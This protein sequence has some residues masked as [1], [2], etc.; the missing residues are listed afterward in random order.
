MQDGKSQPRPHCARVHDYRAGRQASG[1]AF[2]SVQVT[3]QQNTTETPIRLSLSHHPVPF[4]VSF[5]WIH[6][7]RYSTAGSKDVTQA[8]CL[9]AGLT[10]RCKA[11]TGRS[12][13]LPVQ[14]KEL[15]APFTA[16]ACCGRDGLA[17]SGDSLA[18]RSASA[19]ACGFCSSDSSSCTSPSGQSAPGIGSWNATSS[20][21]GTSVVCVSSICSP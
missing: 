4:A 9:Q 19:R 1:A 18:R 7:R 5:L 13:L 21:C 3:H 12:S 15:L 14:R 10:L 17:R 11:H 8:G 16:C 2:C 20:C 6:D